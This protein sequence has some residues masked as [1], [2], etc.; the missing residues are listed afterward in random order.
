MK[1][2]TLRNLGVMAVVLCLVTTSLLGGTLAKYTSEET[3]NVTA[4]VAAWSFK[5][6][7]LGQNESGINMAS[8]VTGPGI[9][10][11]VIAPGTKGSFDIALNGKGSDVGIDYKIKIAAPSGQDA[12]TL[13]NSLTFKVKKS[14]DAAATSYTLGTEVAGNI[15]Y[16]KDGAMTDKVT[17]EWEWA[18]E[19]D[20]T[21]D[22]A[23]SELSTLSLPITVT[24]TQANPNPSPAS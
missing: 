23:L 15:A 1:K 6:T 4:S 3:G 12:P 8:T 21:N 5:T 10:E 7:G 16:S 13:P 17:I 22:M 18:Y 19:G 11:D 20:D 2:S 9:A 24:A 14:G